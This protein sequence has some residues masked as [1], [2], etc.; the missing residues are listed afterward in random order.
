VVLEENLPITETA[1]V[2]SNHYKEGMDHSNKSFFTVFG[3]ELTELG[4]T[5]LAKHQESLKGNCVFILL[6]LF[7]YCQTKERDS[8]TASISTCQDFFSSL[9]K[10]YRYCNSSRRKNN[11]MDE[12]TVS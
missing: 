9:H 5:L 7:R 10:I 8:E 11:W 2:E 3:I 12:S 6:I 4:E 1:D